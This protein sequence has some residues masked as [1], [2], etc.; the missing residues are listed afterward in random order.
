MDK[1]DRLVDTGAAAEVCGMK[2][3]T[4]NGWRSTD[5]PNQPPFVRVGRLVRYR[6]ADLH[7][8]IETR[9]EH[10]GKHRRRK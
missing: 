2:R 10:P 3:S 1:A 8:W 6:L 4:L 7:A 9:T 5:N